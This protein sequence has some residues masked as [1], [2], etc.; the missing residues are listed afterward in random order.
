MAKKEQLDNGL[1]DL[2]DDLDLDFLDIGDEIDSLA[3]PDIKSKKRSPVYNAFEGVIKGA[4][5]KFTD[6]SFQRQVFRDALP[7]EYGDVIDKVGDVQNSV[8]SLYNDAV[9]DVKPSISKAVKHVEKLIPEQNKKTKLVLEKF[10]DALGI[11]DDTRVNREVTKEES[12]ANELKSIFEVQAETNLDLRNQD[13]AEESLKTKIDTDRFVSQHQLLNSISIGVTKLANYNDRINAAYQKKSL[14]LQFRSYFTQAELLSDF[15][16]YSEIYNKQNESIIKNTGLPEYVKLKQSERFTEVARTKFFDNVHE[17]LFGKG[18]FIKEGMGKIKARVKQATGDFKGKVEDAIFAADSVRDANESM[19]DMGMEITP[20]GMGGEMVGGGITDKWAT[21]LAGKVRNVLGAEGTKTGKLGHKLNRYANNLPGLINDL[22]R[23]EKLQD[24][25]ENFGFIEN[26]MNNA[27]GLTKEGLSLFL[28]SSKDMKLDTGKGIFDLNQPGTGFDNASKKSLVTIIP[29]YLARILRE[30]QVFRTGN[31]NVD[32]TLFDHNQ[33]KFLFKSSSTKA[34]KKNLKD[35]LNNNNF[36][37]RADYVT[38]FFTKDNNVSAEAQK[39]LK[40]KLALL[41]YEAKSYDKKTLTDDSFYQGLDPAIAA[42][43]KSLIEDKLSGDDVEAKE[44]ELSSRTVGLRR[45][46]RDVRGNIQ[47]LLHAGQTDQLLELGLIEKKGN[48]YK[49]NYDRYKRLGLEDAEFEDTTDSTGPGIISNNNPGN[50]NRGRGRRRNRGNNNNIPPAIDLTEVTDLLKQYLQR[51]NTGPNLPPPVDCTCIKDYL[52]TPINSLVDINTK[53]LDKITDIGTDVKNIQPLDID[54]LADLIKS[55]QNDSTNTNRLTDILDRLTNRNTDSNEPSNIDKLTQLFQDFFKRQEQ[56]ETTNRE[57]LNE[58]FKNLFNRNPNNDD[59]NNPGLSASGTIIGSITGGIGTGITKLGDA[60]KTSGG[61][62]KGAGKLALKPLDILVRALDKSIKVDGNDT[63][64]QTTETGNKP[65]VSLMSKLFKLSGGLVGSTFGAIKDVFTNKLPAGFKSIAGLVTKGKDFVK[66]LLEDAI[67]LYVPGDLSPRLTAFI[68]R[69]GGYLDQATGKVIFKPSDI[70]GPVVN[71]AGE[72]VLTLEDIKKG[73]IDNRGQQIKGI[74]EKAGKYIKEFVSNTTQKASKNLTKAKDFLSGLFSKDTSKATNLFGNND[75]TFD[76]YDVLVD[77][78][79]IL[80]RGMPVV[81]NNNLSSN[82]GSGLPFVSSGKLQLLGPDGNPI[83]NKS[84]IDEKLAGLNELKEAF[85][86]VVKQQKTT[87]I[88]IVDDQSENLRELF[89]DK[90]PQLPD[91]LKYDS[92]KGFKD[93]ASNIGSNISDK[94]TNN[95]DNMTD[96]IDD[97]KNTIKELSKTL[98]DKLKNVAPSGF[99]VPSIFDTDGNGL[100]QGHWQEQLDKI[101][102]KKNKL[103]ENVPQVPE[104]LR[105]KSDT[106]VV[107]NIMS[108]GGSAIGMLTDKFKGR[109]RRRDIEVDTDSAET[110]EPTEATPTPEQNTNTNETKSPIAKLFSG[111][112]DTLSEHTASLGKSIRN[113]TD[114]IMPNVFDTDGNGLRQGHWKER[115][116]EMKRKQE[117]RKKNREENLASLDPRYKSKENI[118]DT[119]IDKAKGL[120]G[121]GGLLEGASDWLGG[122]DE[123]GRDR[124]GRRRRNRGRGRGRFGGR[125]AGRGLGS[126]LLGGAGRVGSALGTAG[127]FLIGAPGTA[128]RAGTMLA[129]AG[130]TLGAIATSPITL[131]ALGVGTATYGGYKLFKYLNRNKLT[132]VDNVRLAQYGFVPANK[133]LIDPIFALEEY[134]QSECIS[135][136]GPEPIIDDNKLDG[137]AVLEMF[138]ITENDPEQMENFLQ[139]FAHRFKPVFLANLGALKLVSNKG[140]L[141]ALSELEK[142]IQAKYLEVVKN[143]E[144][145]YNQ[146]VSPLKDLETL[147]ANKAVVDKTI[148]E[149]LKEISD[150]RTLL[151]KGKDNLVNSFTALAT[152]VTDKAKVVKDKV[153]QVLEDTG[154]KDKLKQLAEVTKGITDSVAVAAK[155]V[156]D[157]VGKVFDVAATNVKVGAKALGFVGGLVTSGKNR[158]TNVFRSKL[159]MLRMA[160]YGLLPEQSDKYSQIEKLE[161]YFLDSGIIKFNDNVP[162]IDE[163]RPISKPMFNIF[164]AISTSIFFTGEK[165]DK[166]HGARINV[167]FRNRFTPVFLTHLAVLKQ[168]TNKLDL[169]DVE[170]L[171][172]PAKAKYINQTTELEEAIYAIPISPYK[173]DKPL[174]ADKDTVK[175]LKNELLKELKFSD[176]LSLNKEKEREAAK[177]TKQEEKAN[178]EIKP[179]E[180]GKVQDNQKAIGN[181]SNVLNQPS[182]VELAKGKLKAQLSIELVKKT[183]DKVTAL[184]AVRMKMYGLVEIEREKITILRALED[185]LVDKVKVDSAGTATY[186]GSIEE[187]ITQVGGNFGIATIDDEYAKHWLKWFKDRFI[188]VYLTYVGQGYLSTNKL[189][190]YEIE[191]A[192]KDAQKL[193]MANKLLAIPAIWGLINSPWK[194]YKINTDITTTEEN[195]K[196]LKEL[197][198]KEKLFEEKAGKINQPNSNS[199]QMSPYE[200]NRK[201][202]NQQILESAVNAPISGESSPVTTPE[203]TSMLARLTNKT[204]MTGAESSP[205][206]GNTETNSPVGTVGNNETVASSPIPNG[207]VDTNLG[208]NITTSAGIAMTDSKEFKVLAPILLKKLMHQFDLTPVQAAAIVGNLAHESGGFKHHQELKPLKGRGGIGWAQWTASRRVDFEKFA[209]QNNLDITSNAASW[210]FLVKELSAKYHG[211]AITAI[212]K[213]NTLEKAVIAFELIFE[214]A[215][216][217]YKHYPARIKY[218]KQALAL[219]AQQGVD[220]KALVAPKAEPTASPVST[221][222]TPST[223]SATSKLFNSN[224]PIITPDSQA[225]TS[226]S[227]SVASDPGNLNQYLGAQPNIGL[228]TPTNSEPNVNT[229]PDDEE[230]PKQGKFTG[231]N[232]ENKSTSTPSGGK[233]PAAVG[234]LADPKLGDQ[235][236]SVEPGDTIK[237]INP[238]FMK[239]FKGMAAEYGQKTGKKILVTD[240]FRSYAEQASLYRRIPH[241]AARPG[242]SMH[243][244]GLAMDIAESSANEL[245]K[246]GLLRKYGITRPIGKEKWHIEPAGVQLDVN[247]AKKNVAWANERITAGLGRGGGGYALLANSVLKRRDNPYAIKLL[248]PEHSKFVEDISGETAEASSEPIIN[249]GP[250]QTGSEA[251]GVASTTGASVD[252][253]TSN[254][255]SEA[256]ATGAISS[257]VTGGNSGEATSAPGNIGATASADTGIDPVSP[258]AEPKPN[259]P[260]AST[261]TQPGN[262]GSSEPTTFTGKN[263]DIKNIIVKGAKMAGMDPNVMLAFAAIESDLNPKAKAGTSSASGLFQFLTGT[264][265]EV[266]RKYGKKYNLPANASRYDPLASTLMGA[267]YAKANAKY[268]GKSN[269]NATDLYLTHFLGP[270]GAKQFLSMSDGAI[271]AQTMPKQA[272]AN[273][274]IFFAKGGGAR[275]KAQIYAELTRRIAM[276]AKQHGITVPNSAGAMTDGTGGDASGGYADSG[277]GGSGETGGNAGESYG[278]GSGG[279]SN[280]GGSYGSS[281]STGSIKQAS[282]KSSIYKSDPLGDL[283]DKFLPSGI[284][285]IVKGFTGSLPKGLQSSIADI[286]SGDKAGLI[287][288]VG[289]LAGGG[290]KALGG[291]FKSSSSKSSSTTK[292]SGY[293]TVTTADEQPFGSN[294]LGGLKSMVTGK[295]VKA[296]IDPSLKSSSSSFLSQ[297]GPASESEIN[298]NSSAVLEALNSEPGTKVSWSDTG[299]TKPSGYS[300]VTTADEQPFGSNFLGGL[301]SM[302]T[303]KPVKAVIDPSLKSSSSSFLSQAGPASESEI[304]AN[305]SAVLEALNSEPG[306]KVSWSD[307]GT[308]KPSGYSTVTTADEQPFGSNFLGGL[309]SMVTGKP[310]K[311]V[312]DPS[313][314]SSSSSFLSQAGPASESEINANSSA[315]L[316]ALNSEPGTKVS[317][318][319]T[320]TTKPSGYSTVTTADEQPFGSNFLGGLKS[321]VTGKPVKAVIDPSIGS[322]TSATKGTQSFGNIASS[323]GSGLTSGLGK[324]AS[325]AG[326]IFDGIK[327]FGDGGVSKLANSFTSQFRPTN[328][329]STT[330]QSSDKSNNEPAIFGKTLVGP[331]ANTSASAPTPSLPALDSSMNRSPLDSGSSMGAVGL[332]STMSNVDQTLTKSLDIQTQSLSVLKEILTALNNKPAETK[333]EQPAAGA[334][335]AASTPAV[336]PSP[337]IPGATGGAS[338]MPKP[339]AIGMGR[340]LMF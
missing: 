288:G 249:S 173:D 13:K 78:K 22:L 159:L 196:F 278:S 10:K 279:E 218:A 16:K 144:V 107:D 29:G 245:E 164:G 263:A 27:K 106:N 86:E 192:L 337:T 265:K 116:E 36:D 328:L 57:K 123:D 34:T 209:K 231:P 128:L 307:T 117:E 119:M 257:G 84:N 195:I 42:E 244:F 44:N 300:T 260:S 12:L 233:I 230:S 138:N 221:A 59:P 87:I 175:K 49:I 268:A 21:W 168:L 33:D 161:K 109:G 157:V 212:K 169:D 47:A 19:R 171:K 100:R 91:Y 306:T 74:A 65:L 258:D 187:L 134:L 223:P 20:E 135:F 60:L 253:G 3:N 62:L 286:A 40:E 188:P 15:K 67:D 125:G 102:N 163:N 332:E 50:N 266:L 104:S 319:D 309:K 275:T 64:D 198:N 320:G 270:G 140:K 204:G 75:V 219:A 143:I 326:S 113:A 115:L 289:N 152:N 72:V 208:G 88:E 213:T 252:P 330:A 250:S 248:G 303:G 179:D 28:E 211:R 172:D 251:G 232:K 167:W 217:R 98:K 95:V 26:L 234:K 82:I 92:S 8:V 17:G 9:K 329:T 235:Y 325:S 101:K 97:L 63:T 272:K 262:V 273:K 43:L 11:Y 295:P 68:M 58:L 290:L 335:G 156:T 334:T 153:N 77:I 76:I 327:S 94:L 141:S 220:T 305:S 201:S 322:S 132:P 261:A 312:I 154:V 66:D 214:G 301:K 139:W 45:T 238:V 336:T 293:S 39:A 54:K 210:A 121:E 340:R 285:D 242:N 186:D 228:N 287:K 315:V 180:L 142:P 71:L 255:G 176:I 105:Y 207:P 304:D 6:S 311:A 118:I 276:K 2:D 314:K 241:K 136:R 41:S 5:N 46:I 185:H 183:R 316:E 148:E 178:I 133:K 299:T 308:T 313:L 99:N 170:D 280:T 53:I 147:P 189:K 89:K 239:Y 202:A 23:S 158:V 79:K 298:A 190:P 321:M 73:I 281:S 165:T 131:T 324:L 7:R 111:L 155:P 120:F 182:A 271:P 226:G 93:N 291:L 52:V 240:G 69:N 224:E 37:K 160:Q 31:E 56:H 269:P 149:A 222:S 55:L 292:P 48:E 96:T 51:D 331:E 181:L 274:S 61:L 297:A 254:T 282:S 197:A 339:G 122:G 35:A 146:T 205:L 318:S 126:R 150:D 338:S 296:V 108:I 177:V 333:S 302:V 206:P 110:T 215:D 267:E 127:R 194:D 225:S 174:K 130:T 166:V 216:P 90:V 1:L 283:A 137:N 38:E 162:Y 200:N 112:K 277:S 243:E 246:L 129:G 83:N 236:I 193:D 80:L 70:K 25:Y 259:E 229:S 24:K 184:E 317:W 4:K 30:I 114:G 284:S 81:T 264:W 323:L 18:D 256:N 191:L 310:V 203:K 124:R 145:D 294:F 237:G 14:E 85:K 103:M 32:L 227:S 151:G 199:P 247:K